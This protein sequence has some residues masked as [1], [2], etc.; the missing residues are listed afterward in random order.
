MAIFGIKRF[1]VC[2]FEYEKGVLMCVPLRLGSL[3]SGFRGP[4]R[5]RFAVFGNLHLRDTALPSVLLELS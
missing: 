4:N 1:S 2:F 3:W 5:N